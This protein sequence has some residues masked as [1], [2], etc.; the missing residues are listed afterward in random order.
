MRR[1]THNRRLRGLLTGLLL[2]AL[3][4][5]AL[6]PAGFMPSGHGPFALMICHAAVIPHDHHPGTDHC[7]FGAA[8]AAG[9]IPELAALTSTPSDS[10]RIDAAF[11]AQRPCVRRPRAHP[12]RGPPS[13][14]LCA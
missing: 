10:A 4:F 3:A 2:V 7:P 8:P 13:S 9:P 5:R 6:T 1:L 14:S 11:N 12:P